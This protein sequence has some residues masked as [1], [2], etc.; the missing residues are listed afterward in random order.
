VIGL[1]ERSERLE[2]ERCGWSREASR[3][4]ERQVAYVVCQTRVFAH[5]KSSIYVPHPD[6]YKATL[7]RLKSRCDR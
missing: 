5:V 4:D 1:E 7:Y 6:A 2:E 3:L